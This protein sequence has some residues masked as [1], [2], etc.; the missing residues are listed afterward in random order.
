M[1]SI[2]IYISSKLQSRR[3]RKCGRVRSTSGGTTTA[4]F[5]V[6]PFE[7]RIPSF[8]CANSTKR[9][10]GIKDRLKSTSYKSQTR[11]DFSSICFKVR[12]GKC[13]F[14][15]LCLLACVF[16]VVKLSSKGFILIFSCFLAAS[17]ITK[18]SYKCLR[19][20]K[21]TKTT[22]CQNWEVQFC[23]SLAPGRQPEESFSPKLVSAPSNWVSG[24]RKTPN[25]LTSEWKP[26]TSSEAETKAT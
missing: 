6:T 9:R 21:S 22:A 19:G 16:H 2:Y 10:W 17:Q 1:L 13:M 23:V 24:F 4:L 8:P 26:H 7:C 20:T 15:S 5:F 25:L 14:V 3:I 18:R 12:T 11:R